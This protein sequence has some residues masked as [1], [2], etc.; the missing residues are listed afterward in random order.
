MLCPSIEVWCASLYFY[1]TKIVDIYF[2]V[3][4]MGSNICLWDHK[5]FLKIY[6]KYDP[7]F[8]FQLYFIFCIFQMLI[9]ITCFFYVL[10]QFC[11]IL[12]WISTSCFWL[13]YFL[14]KTRKS[15]TFIDPWWFCPNIL[16]CVPDVLKI[17][18]FY[19]RY[20]WVVISSKFSIFLIKAF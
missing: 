9:S 19:K 20:I 10:F 12:C 14:F 3:V 11:F 15:V 5:R 7:F 6:A 18:K 16:A 13:R 2:S 8:L 4:V 1:Y 17:V